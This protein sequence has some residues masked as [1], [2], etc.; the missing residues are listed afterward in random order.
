MGIEAFGLRLS[1][2]LCYT[3]LCYA[4]GHFRNTVYPSAGMDTH[5][6]FALNLSACWPN[7]AVGVSIFLLNILDNMTTTTIRHSLLQQWVNKSR[8]RVRN[9]IY[10]TT[11]LCNITGEYRMNLNKILMMKKI[12]VEEL[13]VFLHNIMTPHVILCLTQYCLKSPKISP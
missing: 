9:A 11:K 4:V 7:L 5:P 2:P 13:R 8:K 12:K 3:M 10:W 6:N 1:H